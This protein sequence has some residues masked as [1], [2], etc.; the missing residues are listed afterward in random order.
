MLKPTAAVA[1]LGVL[2][3]CAPYLPRYTPAQKAFETGFYEDPETPKLALLEYRLAKYFA[4]KDRPYQVVCASAGDL[5]PSQPN[6]PPA[7]LDQEVEL[8]LMKRFPGLSPLTRCK[9][10]GID[11]VAS[12]TGVAAAIFDV[13]DFSCEAPDNCVGWGGYYANGGHG[14]SYYRLRFVGGQWRIAKEDLGI[15]LT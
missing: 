5:I 2:A 4:W 10:Q 6:S 1:A 9:R 14:W 8:K 15:V 7:P 11:V 12:D 3:A 13:N